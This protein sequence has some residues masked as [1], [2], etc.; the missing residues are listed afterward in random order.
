MGLTLK[1]YF[2]ASVEQA[3]AQARQELGPEAMLVHSRRTREGADTPAEYEVVFGLAGEPERPPQAPAPATDPGLGALAVE[4]AHLRRQVEHITDSLRRPV[5]VVPAQALREPELC[6]LMTLLIDRGIS[7][8]LASELA[9]AARGRAGERH[10]A[11]AQTPQKLRKALTEELESRFSVD[12]SLGAPPA[13][14]GSG[15]RRVVALVGPA[16]AGKTTTLVKL[17]ANYGLTCRRPAQILS[18]DVDRVAGSE[19]LRSYAAILGLPFQTIETASLLAPVL[20]EHR[21]KEIVLIDTPGYSPRDTSCLEEI[22]GVITRYPEIDTHLVLSAGMKTSDLRNAVE[23][24]GAFKPAK[25]L[26]TKLDE[27]Q[28]G[29]TI[30]NEAIRARKPVSF[31]S[32]GQRIPEDLEAADKAALIGLL[33]NGDAVR[34]TAAIA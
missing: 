22:A 10:P 4:L 8:D 9:L 19:Q 20:E 34:A 21:H 29:G 7:P 23:R 14:A 15:G 25:L 6:D 17:A 24:F 33:L 26:F 3:L 16:G 18:I 5:A 30:L 13:A 1:S 12:P 11:G 28:P 27:T 31:L 2:A 32:A